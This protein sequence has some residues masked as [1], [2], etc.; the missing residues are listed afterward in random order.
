MIRFVLGEKMVRTRSSA[1]LANAPTVEE[2]PTESNHA[3]L[4]N[5][6]KLEK[7]LGRKKVKNKK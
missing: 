4:E 7:K 6:E 2:A 5:L 3:S 1:R